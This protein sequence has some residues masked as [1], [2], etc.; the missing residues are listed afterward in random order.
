MSIADIVAT[1]LSSWIAPSCA[2]DRCTYLAN[3]GRAY[4]EK[5]CRVAVRV[6]GSN[7]KAASQNEN[8]GRDNEAKEW[9]GL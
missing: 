8:F 4:R 7:D 2:F 6:I 3:S 1:L 9:N 5:S